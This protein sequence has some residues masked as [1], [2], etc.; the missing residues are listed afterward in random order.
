MYFCHYDNIDFY[1]FKQD[2]TSLDRS[3]ILFTWAIWRNTGLK[4]EKHYV[5]DIKISKAMDRKIRLENIGKSLS[6]DIPMSSARKILVDLVFADHTYAKA[7]SLD[8]EFN[9]IHST[10]L[11][12]AKPEDASEDNTD[13]IDIEGVVECKETKLNYD[14]EAGRKQMSE[15]EQCFEALHEVDGWQEDD[16]IT[17][18]FILISFSPRCKTFRMIMF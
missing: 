6:Y 18:C 8:P 10:N 16:Q 2:A 14:E 17:R 11:L 13:V 1:V 3:C 7:S 5:K 9:R 12:F 15:L 4:V